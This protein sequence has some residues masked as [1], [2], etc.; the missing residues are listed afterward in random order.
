M[1]SREK[2]LPSAKV[3]FLHEKQIERASFASR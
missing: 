1:K 3:L 2:S